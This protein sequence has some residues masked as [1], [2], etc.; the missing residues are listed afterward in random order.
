MPSEAAIQQ[1]W[2]LSLVIFAAVLVVVAVMLTLIL[3]TAR[4][5]QE[6]VAAIWTVGQ[7]IANNT[8]QIPL[9]HRTNHLVHGILERAA[10]T[11]QAVE[12][13]ERHAAACPRCPACVTGARRG[14]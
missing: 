1:V 14:A 13:I 5:I 9:L 3:G 7:K 10:A 8:I 11:A 12:A 4:R 2:I 6:G